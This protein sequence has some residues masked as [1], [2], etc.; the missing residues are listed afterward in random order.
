MRMKT[1]AQLKVSRRKRATNVSVRADLLSAARNAGINLSA[2]L[3]HALAEEL[4]R[5]RRDGWRK[6][7]RDAVRA[8]ND[9][10]DKHGVFSD[11]QRSF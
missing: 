7:N 2:T 8:Y 4:A 6:Q 1:T 10:V 9:H 5:Q 11:G 3:E